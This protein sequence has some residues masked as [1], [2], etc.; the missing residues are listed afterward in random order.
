MANPSAERLTP[1]WLTAPASRALLAALEGEARF[2]GGC[3]RNA[4]LGLP[5]SDIDIAT[6]LEPAEVIT[7]L[8]AAGLK[9]I[10]TGIEHGTV[11]AVVEGPE[12]SRQKSLFEVTTLRRDVSTDGRRATVAFTADWAEDAARRDFTMNA[13][14]L[15]GD[16]TLYDPTGKGVG[17]ARARQVRF[18]GDA[19][20]RLREDALRLL[21]FFRFHAQYGHGQP[22]A[23][24]L[25]ACLAEAALLPALSGERIWQELRKLLLAPLAAE[26]W[27]MLYEASIPALL[28]PEIIWHD[29]RRLAA[30]VR[31]GRG[32]AETRLAAVVDGG[33]QSVAPLAKRLRLSNVE[34]GG[35]VAALTPEEV[36]ATAATARTRLYRYG[37]AYREMTALSLAR[38]E[39]ELS[40]AEAVG[41]L[42]HAE[43]PVPDFPFRGRDL[44]ALG[45]LPGPGLGDTIG[46]LE[47]LW[48]ASG[49]TLEREQLEAE[50]RSLLAQAAAS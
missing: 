37:P 5:A 21:R 29:N 41:R 18:V 47:E 8:K 40:A 10:P 17:D 38:R 11:T 35:L 14:Y 1:D 2:V 33:L 22:D 31:W 23:D 15:D 25:A 24:G 7:R 12:G 16:G 4:L 46:Q 49:C 44:I 26:V 48:L 27:Q 9:A 45:A 43:L 32:L 30:L 6:P 20:E 3:V 39:P 13:L 50:A 36:P 19:R 42:A 28:V 34:K